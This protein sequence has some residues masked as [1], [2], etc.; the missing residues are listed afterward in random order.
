MTPPRPQPQTDLAELAVRIRTGDEAAATELVAR[1]HRG[2][3][4]VLRRRCGSVETAQDLVQ[5][6]FLVVLQKIRRDE[7][8]D[9][10]RLAGF[11]HGTAR[12]LLLAHRRKAGRLVGFEDEGS[13]P[14]ERV[15]EPRSDHLDTL[16]R[17]EESRLV[18]ELLREMPYPRDRQV[19]I[20]FYLSQQPKEV[21]CAD[22]DIEPGHFRRVLYRAR[23]RLRQQWARLE[24]RH[25]LAEETVG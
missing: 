10:A 6:T 7:V 22:L 2:L 9:P 20:R 8:E 14:D 19:L 12:H 13:R 21:I 23:E 16:M 17:R 18:R 4:L 5:E 1:F 11:I 25:R 3:T 15:V 24:K